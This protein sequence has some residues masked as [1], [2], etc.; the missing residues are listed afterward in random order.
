MNRSIRIGVEGQNLLVNLL[1]T[2]IRK[3]IIRTGEN[4]ETKESKLANTST[5]PILMS[6]DEDETR[7]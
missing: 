5:F 6:M 3:E 7:T 1:Y 2:T 4:E